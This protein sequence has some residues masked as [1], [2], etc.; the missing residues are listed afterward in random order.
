MSACSVS[1]A[2]NPIGLNLGDIGIGPSSR[3]RVV[4][5]DQLPEGV[6]QQLLRK[7]NTDPGDR[8]AE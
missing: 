8:T 4:V 3:H 7:E 5:G 2:N 6:V 1:S